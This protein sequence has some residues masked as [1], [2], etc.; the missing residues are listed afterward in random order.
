MVRRD[1]LL[2]SNFTV[3]GY[4]AE[5][6]GFVADYIDA[7]IS[8]GVAVVYYRLITLYLKTKAHFQWTLMY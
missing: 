8:I 5:S 3:G 4:S 7:E 2:W 1:L 6:G